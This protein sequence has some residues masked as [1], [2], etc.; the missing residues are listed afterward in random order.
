M[1]VSLYYSAR[2]DRPLSD[3]ERAVL[4]RIVAESNENAELDELLEEELDRWEGLDLWSWAEPD[5]ILSGSS[6]LPS[7]SETT[8]VRVV[9]HLC[10][11]LS[12]LRRAVR[13]ASW[14]VHID[15]VDVPWDD[16]RRRYVPGGPTR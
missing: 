9:E 4:E 2:R 6:Q 3:E 10:A 11:A 8:I 5:E 12:E 1:S 16:E 14:H 15:D 13:D 7:A